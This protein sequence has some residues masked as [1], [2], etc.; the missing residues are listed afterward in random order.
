MINENHRPVL[1]VIAGPN[2]SG[3]TTITSRILHHEWMEN[4]IY[5]NPDIIA[6]EK[7]GDWNSHEAIMKAVDYSERLR[8]ECLEKKQSII[9]ETVLSVESKIDYIKRAKD[10]GFFIR[11]FFVST[12]S[13]TINASRIA[14]RVLEG[15][16]DVPITKIISRYNR[17][18]IN[19]A[20][21]SKIADRAY[22]YDNSITNEDAK[23]LFRMSEGEVIK[24]YTSEIPEWQKQFTIKETF[25]Y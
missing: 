23:L 18:I 21:A 20:I 2:G 10:A 13:P 24:Q 9:F 3:K 5:I 7:F 16:H 12:S 11:L 1:I 19:C 17:S 15:G 8:E 14:K 4:A 22:V 25:N 6:Q